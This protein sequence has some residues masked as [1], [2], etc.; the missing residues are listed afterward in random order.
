MQMNTF[1]RADTT[2]HVKMPFDS[3]QTSICVTATPDVQPQC[4]GLAS[5]SVSCTELPFVKIRPPAVAPIPDIKEI[6]RYRDLMLLLAKRNVAAMYRM[7]FLGVGWAILRPVLM[8]SIFTLIFGLIAG[9]G[10]ETSGIPYP[11]F[12]FAG[13]IP[14]TFF[15]TA[16]ANATSSVVGAQDMLTK[17]YFPRLILP[18]ASLGLSAVEVAIQFVLLGGLLAFYRVPLG[19]EI[20]FLPVILSVAAAA[21]VGAGVWLT[22]LN[23]RYR[24]VQ[25]ALPFLTQALMYLCPIIY[26]ASM[27]P[28]KWHFLYF[29]NPMAGVIEGF[30]WS[31]FGI[32]NPNWTMFT[33]SVI[34]TAAVLVSGLFYFSRTEQ[35][36]ADI[37]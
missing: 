31:V 28:E 1:L 9:L 19:V 10:E 4:D 32:G 33:V 20:L 27:I 15:S 34:A 2:S 36:F 6:W 25:F 26:P 37:I 17:V 5:A 35:T 14:W 12:A 24:D 8:T 30:R 29:L 18:L 23:V 16:L 13:L 11:V 21:A 7:S 22:A 3:Y